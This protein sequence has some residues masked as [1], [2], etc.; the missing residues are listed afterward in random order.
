MISF[1]GGMVF[2]HVAFSAQSTA[3]NPQGTSATVSNGQLQDSALYDQALSSTGSL[4]ITYVGSSP[5]SH[6]QSILDVSG[7]FVAAG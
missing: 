1:S 3:D 7:Y 2:D 6:T 4:S 5:G